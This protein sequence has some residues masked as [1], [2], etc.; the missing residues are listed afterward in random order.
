MSKD[1]LK[2]FIYVSM[3]SADNFDF[4]ED[5]KQ[6]VMRRYDKDKNISSQ[7]WAHVLEPLKDENLRNKYIEFL[8][9]D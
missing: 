4:T 3:I 2:R 6:A 5:E 1:D 9:N 7:D 8:Q